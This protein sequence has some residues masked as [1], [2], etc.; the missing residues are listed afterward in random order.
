MGISNEQE[1][2]EE[3]LIIFSRVGNENLNPEI[4]PHINQNE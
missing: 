4:P 3:I 1:A 2:T